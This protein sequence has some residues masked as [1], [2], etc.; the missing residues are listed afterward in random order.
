MI[1]LVDNRCNRRRSSEPKEV[2]TQQRKTEGRWYIRAYCIQH[3]ENVRRETT[4]ATDDKWV[5][6]QHL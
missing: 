4:T 1:G 5:K 2:Q 3:M 6:I